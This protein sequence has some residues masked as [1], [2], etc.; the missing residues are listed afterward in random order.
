MAIRE[1]KLIRDTEKARGHPGEMFEE[2]LAMMEQGNKFLEGVCTG[3]AIQRTEKVL[4]G[5]SIAFEETC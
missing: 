3:K 2:I 1:D 5:G 4:P